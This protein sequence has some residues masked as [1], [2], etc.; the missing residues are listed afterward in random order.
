MLLLYNGTDC[1]LDCNP[2]VV[3][4]LKEGNTHHPHIIISTII[5]LYSGKAIYSKFEHRSFLK[6]ASNQG[7]FEPQALLTSS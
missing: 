7:L 4:G 1:S 6:N 3:T 5:I 2:P